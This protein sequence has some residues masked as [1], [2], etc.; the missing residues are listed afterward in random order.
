MTSTSSK[1]LLLLWIDAHCFP[2]ICAVVTWWRRL[3]GLLARTDRKTPPRSIIF[4]KLAEQGSTVLA[5]EMIKQATERVGRANVYFLMFEEN[6]FILDVMGLV[7]PENVLTIRTRS[8]WSMAVSC[9][10]RLR[11]IRRRRIDACIDMEFFARSSAVIAYLMGTRIRVGFHCYFGEGPY[12][13]DLFTHRVLYNAHIHA[14]K[15]FLTLV[16]ALDVPPERLPTF[17]YAPPARI[18][19]P[20]FEPA[21]E[22]R[23]EVAAMLAELA[24]V[25]GGKGEG[26]GGKGEGGGGGSGGGGEGNGGDPPLAVPGEARNPAGGLPPLAEKP[27]DGSPPPPAAGARKRR[28][29]LLNANASDLMPLRKWEQLN[30]VELARR[31]LDTFPDAC[32]GFTGG[33]AE[34]AKTEGLV[35]QVGSPRC[36]CLAGRTTLRQLLIVYGLAEILVTNDSGPAHFAALTPV[37]VVVLFGPETPLLFG[38]LSP[39][40]HNVWAG[41]ACSPCINA[42]N[43]RQTACRDAA[44]MK[45]ITVNQVFET[46]CQVYRQRTTQPD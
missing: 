43:N 4:L 8:A 11:E 14:S 18:G 40:N 27:G 15:I 44:C 12:R 36:F 13:G 7:P 41:L 25:D 26:G 39:R 37:D 19:L 42:W 45:A 24:L 10:A 33:P 9:L 29:I 21:A 23:A 46:V 38:T 35:R 20:L 2:V 3:A 28:L 22:E 31:L 16:N 17:D 6:R 5:G 34:A 32:I 1:T 30:Y